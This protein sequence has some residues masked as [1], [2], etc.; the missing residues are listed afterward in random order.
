MRKEDNG[1]EVQNEW[2]VSQ[3]GLCWNTK[4]NLVDIRVLGRIDPGSL[5]RS[6]LLAK[7]VQRRLEGSSKVQ[8]ADNPALL[9]EYSKTLITARAVTPTCLTHNTHTH[10]P[11]HS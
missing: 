5:G 11:H 9:P 1:P 10:R 3:A 2:A 8:Q 6:R 4:R 7:S